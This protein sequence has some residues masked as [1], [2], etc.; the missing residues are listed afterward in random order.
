MQL[1]PLISL[2]VEALA[3]L[4]LA[5][6]V[7]R[8]NP[9]SITHKLF[10]L[11]AVTLVMWATVVYVSV[12]TREYLLAL[13]TV[14]LSIA[15][16]VIQSLLFFALIHS[17]PRTKSNLSRGAQL[18]LLV[19]GLVGIAI[20]LS[21]YAFT[22]VIIAPP[23]APQPIPGWGMII[24]VPITIG[25]LIA[26]FGLLIKK[27]WSSRGIERIQSKYLLYG[28]LTTFTLLAVLL[29]YFVTVRQNTNF[30]PYSPLFTL[31]FV[32][33]T[34]YTI[35]RHRLMDIR[36]AVARSL[37]FSF[38]VGSF[39][40]LYGTLLIFAVPRVATALNINDGLVA[41]AGA[42]LSVFLARYVQDALQR[43]TDQYLF[44]Q[45]TNYHAALLKVSQHLSRTIKIEEVTQI[46]LDALNN[47]LRAGA[48]SIYLQ[49]PGE[50]EYTLRAA[51]QGE[52]KKVAIT[53]DNV[54]LKYLRHKGRV[55]IKD[56]LMDE[57][58]Q[59]KKD[60]HLNELR[61]ISNLLEWVNATAV[62]PLF[63]EKGLSGFIVLGPKKSGEP[64]L[65][66]DI[67]FLESLAPQ[68]AIALENARLYQE[69]LEFGERLKAEVQRATSELEGANKQLKELDEAKSEFLSVASHQLYTPLT[70]IRGYLSMLTEGDFGALDQKQQPIIG[71]INKS[72]ERLIDLIKNLLDISRIESGRFE[73]SLEVVDLARMAKEI[74]QD[75]MPNAMGKDLKLLFHKSDHALPSIIADRQRLRQV[76]LNYVDNAIKYTDHGH[77]DVRVVQ[78]GE[79]LEFQ[80]SDTGRGIDPKEI[81]NLFT[82]FTRTKEAT[83]SRTQGS[84][85]GLYVARQIIREHHGE[86]AVESSGLGKGSAFM[87]RLPIANSTRSLKLSDKAT[88]VIKA[89]KGGE[90]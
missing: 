27:V 65:Q 75:L 25:A 37:S 86:A 87:V 12:T 76:I 44:Q 28:F 70:A 55:L 24:F 58:E 36:L 8:R 20:T 46:V 26:G 63:I 43:L 45:H 10:A 5:G 56:E 51:S 47:I 64:Y 52:R 78:R 89:A 66:D 71:I 30:V 53:I 41:G 88:V 72:A 38:L 48:T 9:Q 77:I 62:I 11:L 32:A 1:L 84:G 6:F 35:V 83:H 13:W 22:E 7:V 67:E 81:A 60:H 90:N 17:F 21:P 18:S 54:I 34:A 79:E 82:K 57:I 68:A 4:T 19:V 85:L 29:L 39:F 74:V 61:E 33:L 59:E 23:K 50:N 15:F 2:I 49:E 42:L 69:S 80:V 40:L 16:A 3:N 73:L 14:R 31:P